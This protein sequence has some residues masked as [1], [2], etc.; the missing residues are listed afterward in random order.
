MFLMFTVANKCHTFWEL[1]ENPNT[2]S[3]RFN[4]GNYGTVALQ[5]VLGSAK[6]KY[7]SNHNKLVNLIG[8]QYELTKKKKKL[9]YR[10]VSHLQDRGLWYVTTLLIMHDTELNP[11]PSTIEDDTS[12]PCGSCGE[13]VT[14]DHDGVGCDRCHQWYHIDCQNMAKHIYVG[15]HSNISW[16]CLNCGLPNFCPTYFRSTRSLH[17]LASPNQFN[18]I[19][20]SAQNG[21]LNSSSNLRSPGH[22]LAASSPKI[23]GKTHNKPKR[24]PTRTAGK[25]GKTRAKLTIKNNIRVLTVNCQSISPKKGEFQVLVDSTKPDVVIATETWLQEGKHHDGE[26]GEANRFSSEFKIYRKDRK[27]GYGGVFVAVSQNLIS[28]RVEVLETEGEIVWVKVNIAGTKDLYIAGCYRPHV[29]DEKGHKEIIDSVE[30]ATT[31]RTS[32]I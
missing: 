5:S 21:S 30:K 6:H 9:L 17:S 12:A 2:R 1:S 3:S 19:S 20:N 10:S 25:K 29:Q 23:Q 28:A 26:I 7:E 11:G 15:L 24:R 8:S 4:T 18:S 13:L 27:D 31:G 14:W 16:E 22:P 32:H